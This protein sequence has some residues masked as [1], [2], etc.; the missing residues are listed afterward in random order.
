MSFK[1]QDTL[2]YKKFFVEAP[3]KG[4]IDNFP[5]AACQN[6]DFALKWNDLLRSVVLI[7][8]LYVLIYLIATWFYNRVVVKIIEWEKIS[9]HDFTFIKIFEQLL[10]VIIFYQL[11]NTSV[12]SIVLLC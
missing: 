10:P 5:Y 12:K 11:G 8:I 1:I 4:R 9:I 7:L 6:I 3:Q 2:H